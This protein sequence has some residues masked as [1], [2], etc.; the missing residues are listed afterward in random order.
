MRF[1]D[2]KNFTNKQFSKM[3]SRGTEE[4]GANLGQ[5][6]SH[7]NGFTPY[8]KQEEKSNFWF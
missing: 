1:V 5:K 2:V 8:Q 6:K 7:K 4:M 3:A